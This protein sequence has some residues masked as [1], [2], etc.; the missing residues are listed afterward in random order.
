M[1][2]FVFVE[3]LTLL[4]W[5]FQ[6]LPLLLKNRNAKVYVFDANLS[7]TLPFAKKMAKG[8]G[9]EMEYLYF[10]LLDIRDK[11]GLLVMKRIDHQDFMAVGARLKREQLES[12]MQEADL[13]ATRKLG[14]LFKVLSTQMIQGSSSLSHALLLVQLVVWK[15]GSEPIETKPPLL[16][17]NQRPWM[18]AIRD[19]AA[20]SGVQVAPLRSGIGAW[21]QKPL[22]MSFFY[23]KIK[24]YL[25]YLRYRPSFQTWKT[26]RADR[27]SQEPKIAVE[28]HYHVN[29][30]RP[31]IFSEFFFWQQ[32]QL[33]GEDLVA[34]FHVP[35]YSLDHNKL[36]ELKEHGVCPIPLRAEATTVAECPPFNPRILMPCLK[37]Q[38]LKKN[39][40]C[41][42]P[43]RSWIKQNLSHYEW[44]RGFWAELFDRFR[45]KLYV[46]WYKYGPEHCAI[47]DAIQDCGGIAALYQRAFDANAWA[48]NVI[49]VDLYFGF[50]KFAAEVERG[51]N[52]KISH[53]VVTGY[54]GDHRFSLLQKP[55]LETRHR[56]LQKGA[57]KIIAYTDENSHE[58]ER[59]LLGHTITR[60]GY[61]FLLEKVL[62]EPW[63]GLVLKPKIPATLR[64]RLGPVA[65]LL[66]KALATG[67]CHLYEERTLNSS[68]PPAL[69]AL[70]AD[71]AIHG[72]LFGPTAGLEAALAGIPSLFMDFEGWRRSPL[73]ELGL[74]KVIFCDW[75]SLW[76]AVL[77]HFKRPKG[78]S[79]LGDW[80]KH[81]H[82]F[83]PFQDGKAAYR[84]GTYLQWLLEAF[85][86]GCHRESALAQANK[87]YTQ[88][89][90]QDKILSI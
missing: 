27:Q 72:H 34:T 67:R 51:S 38:G 82:Q 80:S 47:A 81:I 37:R 71:I 10:R 57:R 30:N 73:Y 2:F 33:R 17:L 16:L 78:E 3:K 75:N 20:G 48:S 41:H 86:K 90:G 14:F 66:E 53:F 49:D 21:R 11:E 46:S 87:R 9:R 43:E 55:A 26:R 54:L 64:Y 31:E 22:W 50:S 15:L 42:R 8:L 79:V 61:A 12:L 52:S 76:E 18:D 85:K 23:R 69:A 56:L 5:F 44:L 13:P 29:L 4:N 59:W 60:K 6:I 35:Q 77:D 40:E 28:C 83:D 1:S 25:W 68:T 24:N 89:W 58:D 39:P 32:S 65:E 7:A 84:M 70:S 36:K 74:G 62:S 19:Y 45:C 88:C 63:L